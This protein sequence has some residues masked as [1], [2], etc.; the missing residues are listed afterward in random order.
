MDEDS[1]SYSI[2]RID[3]STFE[4]KI[5]VEENSEWLRPIRW[6]E[7]GRVLL[8]DESGRYWWLDPDTGQLEEKK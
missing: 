4:Q 3:A 6:E 2:I 5:L 7:S 8:R 1:D